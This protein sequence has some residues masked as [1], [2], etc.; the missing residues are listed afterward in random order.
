[1]KPHRLILA[2]FG[3]FAKRAEIDFDRLSEFGLYLIIGETG[4]GKTTIFDAMTYSLYGE[5]AGNRDKQ[6]VASDYE[7]RDEPY[8]EFHF[9]H[10]NRHFII[11]REVEGRNPS[12]HSITE[13]DSSGAQISAITG[14]S[15]I[16]KYVEELIGLDADQFMKVVLLPQGKFQ[17]F[18]VANSSERE[19]LLQVLFGT[20]VYQKI[21][22]SLV[23]RARLKVDEA[24]TVLQQLKSSEITAQEIIDGL[25]KDSNLGEIPRLELGYDGTL[26][27]LKEQKAISDKSSQTLGAALTAA[28][29]KS[30]AV[31]DEAELFDAKEELDELIKIQNT[32]SKATA[33]AIDS[34]EKHEKAVPVSNAY[35]SEQASLA[36]KKQAESDLEQL[37]KELT[38]IIRVN[39]SEKLIAEI[40]EIRTTGAA[41][42]NAH[43]AK[44]KALIQK[45][46]SKYED[47]NSLTV[48]A[49]EAREVIDESTDRELEIK[50]ELKD[51]VSQQKK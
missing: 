21:S 20:A 4:S 46:Q 1:M 36:I 19:K 51:L 49:E 15:N 38:E 47:A 25:P 48:D 26:S 10:K 18:L 17:D 9:S 8:V 6:S 28:A 50:D 43:I 7:H 14:K 33:A 3:A 16:Q 13:V 40:K 30:Q 37:D 44:T 11:K 27:V 31:G 39:K 41:S 23:E 5:V 29:K 35:K 2:G 12:D 24:N 32:A 42:V 22:D 34:L 45:A